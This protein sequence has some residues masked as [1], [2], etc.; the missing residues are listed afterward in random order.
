MENLRVS[1][2]QVEL[3]WEDIEANLDMFSAKI[4][5]LEKPTDL[6][7]L[8]EMFSTGFSMNAASLAETE[9]GKAVTW[10]QKM[11]KKHEIALTGS[12]IIKDK[13]E[14]YN[15]LF[16]VFPDATF[17]TYSKKHLFTL[18]GE[19]KT[20]SPG[21]EKLMINYK[22]WKICPLI[23]Y[24][25]RFPVWSR[26]TTD[27]DLLLYVANWPAKRTP[28]WDAL[29]K[30]RAIE[31]MSYTIGLNR[32]GEDGNKHAYSGHSA[33]YDM[34]GTHQSTKNFDRI[35]SETITLYKDKLIDARERFGFLRD[36]DEFT[37]K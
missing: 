37:L 8:P 9:T 13:G 6:I 2:L 27:Y 34:L 36:R 3:Y 4:E 7:I 24:D 25:L 30:A 14:Y 21:K 32:V 23:C 19:Q 28:A 1:L 29:L 31:N 10:M 12:L 17:K 33:V 11:A 5:E 22:G 16:F 20:Y 15:R 35:F 26:N 18:A